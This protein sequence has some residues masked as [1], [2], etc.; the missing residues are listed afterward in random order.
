MN[1]KLPIKIDNIAV[2]ECWSF[3][4]LAIIEA[5]SELNYWKYENFT[6][7]FSY[8]NGDI[9]Y[10]KNGQLFDQFKVYEE[11]LETLGFTY[12]QIN[13]NEICDFIIKNINKN[14]YPIIELDF[15]KFINNCDEVYVHEIMFF[16]YD[17]EKEL[18]YI[19][20]LSGSNWI[21]QEISFNDTINLYK[22]TSNLDINAKELMLYKRN[23]QYEITVL[24]PK[25]N[26][27]RNLIKE[28]FSLYRDLDFLIKEPTIER[29]NNNNDYSYIYEGYLSTFN[30]LILAGINILK[31]TDPYYSKK[32]TNRYV[33]SKN[34]KTFFEC[35]NLLNQRIKNTFETLNLSTLNL[36]NDYILSE[37]ELCINLSIKYEITNNDKYISIILNKL[38]EIH[39]K[40]K[41]YFITKSNEE[42]G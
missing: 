12:N 28:I 2:S 5:Y 21:I 35:R 30:S 36:N 25:K 14:S 42:D 41:A 6:N 31:S 23:F 27:K 17:L 19:P 38:E 11:V 7:I 37:L 13:E 26:Y 24:K 9:Y 3:L 34:L 22:K 18:F 33:Y 15:S 29:N 32:T 4:R 20:L 1:K 8:S 39:K 10:G 40:E 16:G